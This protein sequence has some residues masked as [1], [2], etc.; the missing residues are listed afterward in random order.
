MIKT[1]LLLNLPV[2]TTVG[3]YIGRVVNIEVDPINQSIIFYQ[4]RSKFKLNNL[5]H[6]KILISPRQVLKITNQSMIIEDNWQARP[7]MP[8]KLVSEVSQ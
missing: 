4:V 8:I 2:Y 5:W 3:F 1:T 6:K 7:E